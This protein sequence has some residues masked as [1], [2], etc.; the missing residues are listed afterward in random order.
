M[1]VDCTGTRV[2][3][4]SIH[5]WHARAAPGHPGQ[6]RE[7]EPSVF[8]SRRA[9]LPSSEEWRKKA[10]AEA[11]ADADWWAEEG[12][13]PIGGLAWAV[14]TALCGMFAL[15]PVPPL[16]MIG[17]AEMYVAE[18]T[19]IAR[20]RDDGDVF[21]SLGERRSLDY[22]VVP[23]VDLPAALDE[24]IARAW[25]TAMAYYRD[26]Q[27]RLPDDAASP[28][29]YFDPGP[30]DL[31]LEHA[32]I[33][34]LHCCAWAWASPAAL[35]RSAYEA[36]RAETIAY[37][38]FDMACNEWTEMADEEGCGVFLDEKGAPRGDGKIDLDM[39]RTLVR[40]LL[41]VGADRLRRCALAK[42]SGG[43]GLST[44][45]SVGVM[46]TKD[47]HE[48]SDEDSDDESQ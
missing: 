27:S 8:G 12:G 37:F 42:S 11:R 22:L 19:E 18:V 45:V 6:S 34:E 13:M 26:H 4:D 20:E 2:G 7:L 35:D 24:S 48:D 3:G 44:K 41:R 9:F 30:I 31:D 17:A 15:L 21:A 10:V 25:S 33:R 39:L 40:V 43:S 47:M 28:A 29:R 36:A 16:D 1:G 38:D 23:K 5:Y 32:V 14:H 46:G